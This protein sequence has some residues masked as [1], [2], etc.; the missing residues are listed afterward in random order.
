M[1]TTGRKQ[2]AP[3]LADMMLAARLR[4]LSQLPGKTLSV[5]DR[6]NV[7]RHML[8]LYPASFTATT[9]RT[10]ASEANARALDKPGFDDK[11]ED[12]G[13]RGDCR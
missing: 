6:E 2:I 12:S 7:T 4:P 8:L 5:C 9:R 3:L 11:D 13:H 1:R 10:Y